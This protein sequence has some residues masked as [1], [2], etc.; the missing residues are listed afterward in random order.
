MIGEG[1][2]PAANTS[3][4]TTPSFDKNAWAGASVLKEF[5]MPV[6]ALDTWVHIKELTA[7]QVAEISDECT[8][9]K[10]QRVKFDQKRRAARVFAAGVVE[11]EFTVDEANVLMHQHGSAFTLVVSAIDDLSGAGDEAL[12]KAKLR[13]R[14]RR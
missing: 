9:V 1:G 8:S 11:P 7:G 4:S 3:L 13:F 6:E 10:G 14:P 2:D 12:E 5:D